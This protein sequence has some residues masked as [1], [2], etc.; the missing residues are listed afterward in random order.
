MKIILKNSNLLFKSVGPRDIVT[1]FYEGTNVM[2]VVPPSSGAYVGGKNFACINDIEDT[3][4][5]GVTYSVKNGIITLNG[6]STEDWLFIPIA[7]GGLVLPN[8]P[9]SYRFTFLSG[10]ASRNFSGFLQY[11]T[12]GGKCLAL[13]DNSSHR[14]EFKSGLVEGN[15]SNKAS[16]LALYILQGNTFTNVKFRILVCMSQTSTEHENSS[17]PVFT[18]EELTPAYGDYVCG[19]SIENSTVTIK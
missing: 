13:F 5:A 4:K 9:L 1:N 10:T 18:T 6:T 15:R 11:N 3:T 19:Q 7:S 8:A 16:L 2:K 14:E 12:F 17:L